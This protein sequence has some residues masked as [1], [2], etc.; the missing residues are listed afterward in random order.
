MKKLS[1]PSYEVS[2]TLIPKP[3]KGSTKNKKLQ[4]N[5]PHEH[6]FFNKKKKNKIHK[7]MLAK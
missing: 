6:R 5:I 3:D 2:I 7:E 1:N 4:T